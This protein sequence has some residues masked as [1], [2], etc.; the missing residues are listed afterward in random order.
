[1]TRG[2]NDVVGSTLRETTHKG[3][4]QA[5]NKSLLTYRSDT[6]VPG[7]TGF[8]P[9]NVAIPLEPKNFKHT[10]KPVDQ[11][12][13]DS[14]TAGTVEPKFAGSLYNQ[15]FLK[16][17]NDTKPFSKDGGGY[18]FGKRTLSQGR[19]FIASTTN[20]AEVQNAVETAEKQMACTQGL[21]STLAGYEVARQ[22]A[23][24]A[25]PVSQS[26]RLDAYD[27]TRRPATTATS[28]G[29]LVGYQTTSQAMLVADS[30]TPGS[31]SPTKGPAMEP[32][33]ATMPRAMPPGMF[34]TASAYKTDFGEDGSDPMERSAPGERFQSRLATT[35]DLAEGTCRNVNHPPG[36][37]GH[38]PA[39]KYHHLARAQA[40]GAD[41]RMDQKQDMLLYSLD[42]FSRSRVPHCTYTKP[43][44]ARNITSFTQPSQGPTLETVYGLANHK[45]CKNGVPPVDN[46]HFINSNTGILSYFHSGGEYI[47]E[48]GLANAQCYFKECK[49]GAGR[50]QMQSTDKTTAY[51]APFKSANSLV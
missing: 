28:K 38:L 8:I 30:L 1:M 51:G 2:F 33:Y 50:F 41:E 6:G 44:A 35:R 11:A 16:G 4:N 5:G 22:R 49:P 10:G 31:L 39:S 37:T 3:P 24:S 29:Q 19:P 21:A 23:A 26:Q 7:Y 27:G 43:Q 9:A 20:R 17:P 14:Q 47:S 15:T 45:A 25:E 34:G 13:L 46:T 32:R 48:N 42:Q 12:F 36:Y 18:W 40:D